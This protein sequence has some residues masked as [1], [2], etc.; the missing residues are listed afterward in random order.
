MSRTVIAKVSR[1]D[2]AAVLARR[3]AGATTV[4]G[5]LVCAARAGLKV[6]AT[7]GIGGVHPAVDGGHSYDVSADL[8][9][10]SR[11]SLAVVCSGAKSILDLPA[12]VELLETLGVPV[13]G[14]GTRVF[15]AFFTR[16]SGIEI[17]A[18]VSDPSTAARLISYQLS[19]DLGGLLIANPVPA[20]QAIVRSEHDAWLREANARARA[21]GV[22]GF[23]LT[24]FLLDAMK[25]LSDGRT[26]IANEALLVD[27]A[28][29]AGEIA[30][31]L[32]LMAK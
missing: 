6:F 31:A 5:T 26:L 21:A 9:E 19:L 16:D 30:V 18:E 23:A 20:E 27:N 3:G 28:R 2:I 1:R 11:S 22:T 29:V 12:T 15:P 17:N 24:P 7:G 13:I 25:A 32:A 10:L 4:A 14:Y 8:M